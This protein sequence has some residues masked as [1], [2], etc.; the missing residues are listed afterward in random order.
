[1]LRPKTAAMVRLTPPSIDLIFFIKDKH[2]LR[3]IVPG[4]PEFNLTKS[5]DFGKKKRVLQYVS[6]RIEPGGARSEF[7]FAINMT[8]TQSIFSFDN[9][10]FGAIQSILQANTT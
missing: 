2:V 8:T 6:E 1:M 3:Y 5:G 9:I 4:D 7:V 10:P